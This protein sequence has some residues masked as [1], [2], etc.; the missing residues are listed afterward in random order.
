MAAKKR[1]RRPRVRKPPVLFDATQKLVAQI[2]KISGQPLI[3]YWNSPNGSVC[4]NDVVALYELLGKIGKKRQVTLFLKSEGGNGQASL[5]IVHL[6]RQYAGRLT[7]LVPLECASAATM[8]ALG[9]DEIHMGPLA[10]LSAVDTSLTHEL[11]PIDSENNRVS[12]SQDELMRVLSLFRRA[13]EGQDANPYLTL[14]QHVHPLVIGAVDRSSS[15]SVR[16]CTEILSYHMKNARKV[17]EISKQLNERYPSHDFPITLREA[18]RLGL[19][20]RPLEAKLNDALI[21]LSEL[22]AEMGQRAITDFDERNYHDN[23]ILNI[24]EARDIQL[25]YQGDK[26]W[27]YRTEERRWVSLNDQSSWR[28]TER[29]GGRTLRSVFH[30]R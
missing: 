18:Q 17:R 3:A 8:L 6:L 28:R 2:E 5:R 19:T 9:A 22:Y 12:V 15:L 23:E 21:E 4:N 16:L 25:Y 30:L 1:R 29:K 20:V 11:S 24:L 7:A 13:S 26:D 14:Y 10:Y 27:H